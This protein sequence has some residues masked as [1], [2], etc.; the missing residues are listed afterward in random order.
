ML[1]IGK[2]DFSKIKHI[3]MVIGIMIAIGALC[4][5]GI[6][7]Y[8]YFK[9]EP[10]DTYVDG[11]TEMFYPRSYY[12]TQ[13]KYQVK[14][15][16]TWQTRYKT[17]YVVQYRSAKKLSYT[18]NMGTSETKAQ[19]MLKKNAAVQRRILWIDGTKKYITIPADQTVQ[20]Y[21]NQYR[22]RYIMLFLVSVLYLSAFS[23]FLFKRWKISKTEDMGKMYLEKE[24]KCE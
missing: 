7:V 24:K 5:A 14:I 17:V 2:K 12:P 6:S 19:E 3:L 16:R 10:V 22:T 20:G 18:Q 11:G 8:K 1:T 9:L 23:F 13:E 21:I 4:T 15:N